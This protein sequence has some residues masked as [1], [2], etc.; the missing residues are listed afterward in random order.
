MIVTDHKALQYLQTMQ[1][2]NPRLTRW[3]LAIQPFDFQ[4]IHRPGRMHSNADGLSRQAWPD[5]DMAHKQPTYRIAAEEEG[6]SVG[7]SQ[8]QRATLLKESSLPNHN[9]GEC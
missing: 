7:K 9:C 8:Q 5:D 4:V 3:A 6:G 2:A 1:N